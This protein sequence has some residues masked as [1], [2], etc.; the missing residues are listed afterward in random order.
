MFDL[1]I[2]RIQLNENTLYVED[3]LDN[4]YYR[5][6]GKDLLLRFVQKKTKIYSET[7][8]H[9]KWGNVTKKMKKLQRMK[10]GTKKDQEFEI[11]KKK[12]FF[13]ISTTPEEISLINENKKLKDLLQSS[14]ESLLKQN[15]E[16]DAY[17]KNLEQKIQELQEKEKEYKASSRLQLR[18]EKK[19]YRAMLK[20]KK[21]VI[22]QSK[23]KLI[24]SMCV[25]RKNMKFTRRIIHTKEL[26]EE[27]FKEE[28]RKLCV[29]LSLN[30]DVPIRKIQKTFV[31]FEKRLNIKFSKIPSRTS[32][33]NFINENLIVVKILTVRE[34]LESPNVIA[35]MDGTKKNQRSYLGA[36]G[37]T[38]VGRHVTF[39]VSK[40]FTES[41]ENLNRIVANEFYES[42]KL[43]ATFFDENPDDVFQS[44]YKAIKALQLDNAANNEVFFRSFKTYRN[45]LLEKDEVLFR[46]NCLLHF[47]SNLKN[48]VDQEMHALENNFESTKGTSLVFSMLYNISQ[49]LTTYAKDKSS[50]I[51]PWRLNAMKKDKEITFKNLHGS[52]DLLY[53]YNAFALYTHMMNHQC[54]ELATFIDKKNKN[55]VNE[56]A[57]G[58]I[59]KFQTDEISL[60]LLRALSIFYHVVMKPLEKIRKKDGSYLK[61]Q[62]KYL[63][64]MPKLKNWAENIQ[65]LYDPTLPPSVIENPSDL[66]GEVLNDK[67]I[68]ILY[69]SE[70]SSTVKNYSREALILFCSRTYE[71]SR[72]YNYQM[73]DPNSAIN[74]MDEGEVQ[75]ILEFAPSDNST[76]E[77]VFSTLDDVSRIRG[78][79]CGPVLLEASTLYK[80]NKRL[81]DESED[82]PVSKKKR[83]TV[84]KLARSLQ[85][86]A[87]EHE[88]KLKNEMAAK[89][90]ENKIQFLVSDQINDAIWKSRNIESELEKVTPEVDQRKKSLAQRK[91]LKSQLDK[92]KKALSSSDKEGLS[93]ETVGTTLKIIKERLRDALVV[94]ESSL[95][96]ETE[97][98]NS[99]SKHVDF[100]E[101]H[102]KV[103]ARKRLREEETEKD[104]LKLREKQKTNKSEEE[105]EIIIKDIDPKNFVNK[106]FEW[107]WNLVHDTECSS[108]QVIYNGIITDIV[109]QVKEDEPK[110]KTTYRV[111]YVEKLD[112]KING[113]GKIQQ[114]NFY[115][116]GDKS[117][118]IQLLVD[119]AEDDLKLVDRFESDIEK[120]FLSDLDRPYQSD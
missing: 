16:L 33:R 99:S 84:R 4:F 25:N 90:E 103:L 82:E 23:K 1:Q 94:L 3:L 63:N 117:E 115:H 22:H 56:K 81:L 110:S 78:K 51:H 105:I 28:I 83:V 59:K 89:F 113:R 69:R 49:N 102:Q 88:V 47:K 26:G 21:A 40:V 50:L 91:A 98:V 58:F 7:S 86:K 67:V 64:A 111:K 109:Y 31:T 29:D 13:K 20:R 120:N 9:S 27:S 17:V 71:F 79:G 112:K 65:E 14:E 61:V 38:G 96:R 100:D 45:S 101:L 54:Q 34:A 53:F 93:F 62:T 6:N 95:N 46:L 35:H 85:K 97:V 72:T 108:K 41:G 92:V 2:E 73:V 8:L 32:I 75:K 24:C 5:K 43:Y 39:F 119:F 106:K 66:L 114:G 44:F 76:A 10:D 19:K 80:Q 30:C 68:S 87:I 116:Y 11:L 118:P 104:L 37:T 57:L 48:K 74:K 55:S 15:E 60:G 12:I 42:C 52:R 107:K 36:S 70:V 77:R 18:C